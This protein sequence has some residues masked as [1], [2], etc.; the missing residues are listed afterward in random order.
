MRKGRWRRTSFRPGRQK[1]TCAKCGDVFIHFSPARIC[2][3]RKKFCSNCLRLKNLKIKKGGY[4][5]R[6]KAK[7]LQPVS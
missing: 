1:I 6:R 4:I 3:G 2:L 5:E 7:E